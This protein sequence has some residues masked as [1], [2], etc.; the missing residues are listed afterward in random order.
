LVFVVTH[1]A[2]TSTWNPAVV[3]PAEELLFVD[4]A[5]VR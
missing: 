4:A 5:N 3:A 2:E 1:D